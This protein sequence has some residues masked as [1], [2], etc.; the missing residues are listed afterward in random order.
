MQRQKIAALYGTEIG[1]E[2]VE[3]TENACVRQPYL[4]YI[5]RQTIEVAQTRNAEQA[6]DDYQQKEK[7]KNQREVESKR[8]RL[9]HSGPTRK[10]GERIS[11]ENILDYNE[12]CQNG[13]PDSAKFLLLSATLPNIE[14]LCRNGAAAWRKRAKRSSALKTTAR[15]RR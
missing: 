8:T 9:P 2:V 4:R 10:V 5:R 3:I 6:E 1:C 12:L 7:Q 15:P 11:C 13:E 14:V